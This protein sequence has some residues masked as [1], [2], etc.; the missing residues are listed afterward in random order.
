LTLDDV[1]LQIG[2]RDI[3]WL[4][5][6]VEGMEGQVID[7][8]RIETVKPWILVIESTF[9]M[10]ETPT[11][12]SW[13]QKVLNRGYCHAY[14]DGLNRF[15]VA[16]DHPELL[17]YLRT[18]PNVFDDFSLSGL[19]NAPFC[20]HVQ[21]E[22][23]KMVRDIR[24]ADDQA[25]LLLEEKHRS[26]AAHSQEV[27]A[28][29]RQLEQEKIATERERDLLQRLA[30]QETSRSAHQLA[31]ENR[32]LELEATATERERD[33]IQRLADERS[34]SAA[35]QIE[36]AN[37]QLEV[38]RIATERE[39]DLL[40]RVADQEKSRSAQEV[41]TANRQLEQEK[42]AAERECDL[43]QRLTDQERE[44][45]WQKEAARQKVHIAKQ[46][47]RRRKHA[48]FKQLQ[49]AEMD[50]IQLRG[51]EASLQ[52]ELIQLRNN[53]VSLQEELIQLCDNE[54]SAQAELIELRSTETSLQRELNSIQARRPWRVITRALRAASGWLR[55]N[56]LSTPLSAAINQSPDQQIN[57]DHKLSE[58]QLK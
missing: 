7:G 14:W 2:A 35:R 22:H 8:W 58:P 56:T 5:I 28:A 57:V 24:E 10:T 43:L 25:K 45:M 20:L 6:D 15:Y 18:P 44:I 23:L 16:T 49:D 48:L 36:A 19:S 51:N 54:A 12:E 34:L 30:D 40:Q 46:K 1:F 29:N 39:R 11:H 21:G 3:H 33:L 9:P 26:L 41:E 17:G 50:I 37:R 13:E 32:Q 38:Q 27:E 52:A 47:F 55:P 31:T 4:K 42:I 53:A